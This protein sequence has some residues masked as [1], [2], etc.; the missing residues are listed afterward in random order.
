MIDEKDTKYLLWCM[1]Q[2]SDEEVRNDVDA[3][4]LWFENN[5]SRG[6]D[7]G[8]W[9]K[10][11]FDVREIQGEIILNSFRADAF[12]SNMTYGRPLGRD[13]SSLTIPDYVVTLGGSCFANH[14]KFLDEVHISDSV[15]VLGSRC[16]ANSGVSSVRLPNNDK[17]EEISDS[18]FKDCQR[19]SELEIPATVKRL[20]NDCFK[21]CT[22]LR[23]ITIPSSVTVIGADILK[24]TK[25]LVVYTDTLDCDIARYCRARD[26][27]VIAL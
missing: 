25:D 2:V 10:P 3:L 16:F 20:G 12:R 14:C 13:I 8:Y 18:C 27:R 15:S 11:I 5:Y 22:S 17:F 4:N 6:R 26:I 21:G 19:L 7:K 1:T 9:S 24:D 23:R